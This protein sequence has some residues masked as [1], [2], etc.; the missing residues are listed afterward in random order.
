M[1]DRAAVAARDDALLV[2]GIDAGVNEE[3]AFAGMQE[4]PQFVGARE[5]GHR[6]DAQAAGRGRRR[7]IDAGLVA[8]G[9]MPVAL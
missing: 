9:C 4:R 6:L 1:L 8:L 2:V 3:R 5:V 7:E